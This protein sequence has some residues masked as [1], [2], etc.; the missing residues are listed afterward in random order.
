MNIKKYLIINV[1]ILGTTNFVCAKLN[2]DLKI[3]K[4]KLA[5]CSFAIYNDSGSPIWI[6]PYTSGLVTGVQEGSLTLREGPNR[7]KIMPGE[8]QNFSGKDF[9]VY[10]PYRSTR[11][12]LYKKAYQLNIQSSKCRAFSGISYSQIE[13]NKVPFVQSTKIKSGSLYGRG[14]RPGGG[15]Q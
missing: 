1:L 7:K 3:K 6:T 12:I 8:K 4:P 15:L 9:S 2:L 13:Q 5:S 14:S 11:I 10:T